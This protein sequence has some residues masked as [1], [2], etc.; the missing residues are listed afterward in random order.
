[1]VVQIV[2]ISKPIWV[3]VYELQDKFE[4]TESAMHA[5]MTGRA[6]GVITEWH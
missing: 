4:K 1:M 6:V 5:P 2:S 3:A